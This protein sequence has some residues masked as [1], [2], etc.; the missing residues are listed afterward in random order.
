MK[1]NDYI[2]FIDFYKDFD[3]VYTDKMWIILKQYRVI[4]K[5]VKM[6]KILSYITNTLFHS[7]CLLYE[8]NNKEQYRNTIFTVIEEDLKSQ[9]V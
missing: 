8:K 2:H 7:D 4:D 1:Q 9:S 3:V 5:Y 6:V